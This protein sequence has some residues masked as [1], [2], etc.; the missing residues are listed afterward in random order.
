MEHRISDAL[1]GGVLLRDVEE[2]DLPIFLEHQLDPAANQMA[3]FQARD[4]D[5]FMAH[6]MKILGDETVVKK[7]I[8][9]GDQVA[10]N[11]VCYLQSGRWLIG[12]WLARQLWGRGIATRAL[13][14]LVAQVQV[15]P[16]HA[17]VA[18]HNVGSIRVLEK[19][20]FAV[21]GEDESPCPASGEIVEEFVFTLSK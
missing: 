19:C 6:W 1:A 20:G 8:L 21:S 14:G 2:G 9:F 12:Y 3:A 13:A 16:L 18:K 4:R 15:R 11:I 7:T 5:A 17:H 10:G